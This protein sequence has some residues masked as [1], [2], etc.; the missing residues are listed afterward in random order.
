MIKSLSRISTPREDGSSVQDKKKVITANS[1]KIK[2]NEISKSISVKY[3][4]E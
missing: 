1:N 4:Q 3:Q 2:H